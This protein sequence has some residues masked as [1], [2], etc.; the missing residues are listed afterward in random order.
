MREGYDS[1][2]EN[3]EDCLRCVDSYACLIEKL[4]AAYRELLEA[5]VVEKDGES[6]K[7]HDIVKSIISLVEQNMNK[8]YSLS[9]ISCFY[10]L[11]QPYIRKIFKKYTGSSYNK[12]VLE[13]KILFAKQILQE[14]PDILIKDVADALGYEQFY[15]STVFNKNTGMTPTEYKIW[16][17]NKKI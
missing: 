12:Y 4:E 2:Q 7:E 6:S 8:N 13:Q 1:Y 10:G 16:L 15:F 5:A 14:N 9:E 11:S 3:T 17:E